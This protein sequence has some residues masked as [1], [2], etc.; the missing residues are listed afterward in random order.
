MDTIPNEPMSRRDVWLTVA[1]AVAKDNMPEPREMGE[2]VDGNWMIFE[3]DRKADADAWAERLGLRDQNNYGGSWP[4]DWGGP[5]WGWHVTVRCMAER[6]SRPVDDVAAQLVDA[7]EHKP[8][9]TD[10]VELAAA[11]GLPW[12]ADAC[13]CCGAKV[14]N[15]RCDSWDNPEITNRPVHCACPT[16]EVAS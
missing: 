4:A 9:I 14:R 7:I 16:G 5:A 1:L 2:H 12:P 8:L 15:G 11:Y 10:P 3:F 13:S 6:K